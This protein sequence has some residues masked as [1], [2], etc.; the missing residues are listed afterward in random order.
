MIGT[1]QQCGFAKDWKNNTYSEFPR[2]TRKRH[3]PE[4]YQ[5]LHSEN[6]N[7]PVV[8]AYQNYDK[9]GKLE[10]VYVQ[11][12]DYKADNSV[13]KNSKLRDN[14]EN[15]TYRTNERETLSKKR[16]SI[17]YDDDT[18]NSSVDDSEHQSTGGTPTSKSKRAKP[19]PDQLSKFLTNARN[20]GLDSMP[21]SAFDLWLKSMGTV[22][23]L[24]QDERNDATKQ[25]KLACGTKQPTKRK[26]AS[27]PPVRRVLRSG[28]T[29]AKQ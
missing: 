17:F 28:S 13:K 3:Q 12:R 9:N 2:T 29:T 6:S 16:R 18:T 27:P 4:R 11:C 23:P 8:C 26:A 25:Y 24:T 19:T 10:E 21:Q 1:F 20:C 15:I 7:D 14:L 22:I 5:T